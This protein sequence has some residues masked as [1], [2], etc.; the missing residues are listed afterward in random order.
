M[1]C[2]PAIRIPRS[3]APTNGDSLGGPNVADHEMYC[4]KFCPANRNGESWGSDCRE[5][6]HGR[7]KN[8]RAQ[9][10]PFVIPQTLD[11][12]PQEGLYD[13]VCSGIQL[14]EQNAAPLIRVRCPLISLNAL[15]NYALR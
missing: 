1:L 3:Q 13:V 7:A 9:K 14:Y 15:L 2:S 4:D 11:Q 12:E 8:I 10:S 6:S 5:G